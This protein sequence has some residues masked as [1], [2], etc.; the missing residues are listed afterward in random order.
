MK[1]ITLA[2]RSF[3]SLDNVCDALRYLSKEGTSI[4]ITGVDELEPN[5]A[6]Q[7]LHLFLHD[8]DAQVPVE[9]FAT[10]LSAAVARRSFGLWDL[11]PMNEESKLDSK[12][13]V[14]EFLRTL[15]DQFPQ[16]L[17]CACFPVCEGYGQWARS[18]ATW[19]T[20]IETTSAAA[21]EL[22]ALR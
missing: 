9:P 2:I 3:S 6:L 16:C 7:I 18:C 10:L 13:E 20:I 1:T 15:P 12:P 17:N 21:R 22:R 14:Q 4:W 5:E 19:K 11:S 8:T